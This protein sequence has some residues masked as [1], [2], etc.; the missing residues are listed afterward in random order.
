M[1]FV[2]AMTL[3]VA[4]AISTN[5]ATYN[6]NTLGNVVTKTP[7]AITYK[8]LRGLVAVASK[9]RG[10]QARIINAQKYNGSDT[11]WV[12]RLYF[13]DEGDQ[14]AADF[15]ITTIPYSWDTVKLMV[16]SLPFADTAEGT[17]MY[18]PCWY[19]FGVFGTRD[20]QSCGFG[21]AERIK[22]WPEWYDRTFSGVTH[23]GVGYTGSYAEES[24]V[25]FL[26]NKLN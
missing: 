11:T 2:L 18:G 10:K 16:T 4:T 19:Y 13:G 6:T 8:D 26:E 1:S 21:L 23:R 17:K 7:T 14:C 12:A 22:R 15:A 24:N 3:V 25:D 20:H 9:E 5:A